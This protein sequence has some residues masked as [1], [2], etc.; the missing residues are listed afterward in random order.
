MFII[1]SQRYVYRVILDL[2]FC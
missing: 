1:N 2:V